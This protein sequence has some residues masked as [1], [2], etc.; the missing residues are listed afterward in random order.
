MVLHRTHPVRRLS[1]AAEVLDSWLL[2]CQQILLP[3]RC[4]LL[5]SC[6]NGAEGWLSLEKKLLEDYLT[7]HSLASGF[8]F[9]PWGQAVKFLKQRD[10]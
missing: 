3:G 8:P 7:F 2:S 6:G 1:E 4:R 9:S 10:P 5:A